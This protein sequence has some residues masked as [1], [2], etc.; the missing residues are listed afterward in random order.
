MPPFDEL[1]VFIK[2]H[3]K[4][5]ERTSATSSVNK[6]N[7]N[8][9]Y[10]HHSKENNNIVKSPPKYHAYTVQSTPLLSACVQI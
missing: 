9:I 10:R 6:N 3:S 5:F 1:M 2:N 4:V 7:L 8:K